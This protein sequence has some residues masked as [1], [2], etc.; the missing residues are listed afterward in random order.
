MEMSSLK[1][2]IKSYRS[3]VKPI[4]CPGCGDYAVLNSLTTALAELD[5]PAENVAIASGI[6]CSGRFPAFTAAYGFH[7]VHGRPLPLATGMKMANPD[8]TVFAVGG[9]GDGFSIGAEHLPHAPRRNVD[10]TYIV[11][12]NR[13]YSLTKGQPSPTSPVGMRRKASPYGT[14]ET[15]LN[16]MAMMIAYGTSFV[17]QAFSGKPK[18]MTKIIEEAILHKGFSFVHVLSPCVT[19]YDTYRQFRSM[20]ASLPEDYDPTDQVEAFRLA[21]DE[22]KLYI[23]VFYKR[24]DDVPYHERLNAVRPEQRTRDQLMRELIEY[25][26]P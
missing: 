10:L 4:W 22:S 20:V 17:A 2:K 14:V 1:E 23:G 6:G 5:I 3:D 21:L 8:L 16:P 7:G 19:F 18:E 24:E 26:R 9:D 15:P 13:L 11:M 25:Y 12:D